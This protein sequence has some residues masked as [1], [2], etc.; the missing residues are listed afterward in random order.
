MEDRPF[1]GVTYY[2]LLGKLVVPCRDVMEWAVWYEQADEERRV[3]WTEVG[4]LSVSTVFLGLNF[5]FLPSRRHLFF[6]TMIMGDEDQI[7]MLGD[8][9][10]L[11][12]D[13][14][15]YQTRCETWAEAEQMHRVA[16][17]WAK[18]KLAEIDTAIKVTV[19][20]ADISKSDR[21]VPQ[22]RGRGTIV[23]KG[24]ERGGGDR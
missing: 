15:D 20:N 6:E 8:R 14:L 10:R 17:E 16:V 22:P 9:A 24:T 18:A 13:W 23:D 5:G 19:T 4:P 1:P 3:G 11:M 2:K 21:D 12:H 7:V